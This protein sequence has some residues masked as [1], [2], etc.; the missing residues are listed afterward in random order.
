[1]TED[2]D[3]AA[4]YLVEQ[5][6]IAEARRRAARALL[7]PSAPAEAVRRAWAPFKAWRD[8]HKAGGGTQ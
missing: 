4:A 3:R 6:R 5:R 8:E 1:M 2:E 7:A